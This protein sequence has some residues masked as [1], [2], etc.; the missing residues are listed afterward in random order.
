MVDKKKEQL[1][2][3]YGTASYKLVKDI[4]YSMLLEL[5]RNECFHC[6]KPMTRQT[7]SIEHKIAWLNSGN[8][9]DL[10]FD[11]TNIS[12]SHLSCNSSRARKLKIPHSDETIKERRKKYKASYYSKLSKEDISTLRRNK[13][14]RTGT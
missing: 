5:N 7:F 8:P 6:G 14:I 1:G 4:L 9:L 11:L 2:M 3:A 13:Y 10:F 12:F